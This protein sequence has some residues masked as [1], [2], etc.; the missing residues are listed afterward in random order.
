MHEETLQKIAL[1][2]IIEYKIF[3][4]SVKLRCKCKYKISNYF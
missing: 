3:L 4:I 2:K 1:S